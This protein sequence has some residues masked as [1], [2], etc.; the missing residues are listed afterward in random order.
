MQY[1]TPS[2]YNMQATCTFHTNDKYN[3]DN[4]N[5]IKRI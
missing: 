4:N 2:L 3:Q 5:H 1:R